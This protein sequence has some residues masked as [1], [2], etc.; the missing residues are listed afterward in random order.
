MSVKRAMYTKEKPKGQ[1]SINKYFNKIVTHETLNTSFNE[2]PKVSLINN[3][4]IKCYYPFISTLQYNQKV[5]QLL[6]AN[7][8]SKTYA[9]SNCDYNVKT[10]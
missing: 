9:L 2:I 4:N 6:K 5:Y 8:Y 10:E 7:V 1:T 3:P